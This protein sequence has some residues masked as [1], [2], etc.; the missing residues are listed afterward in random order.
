MVVEVSSRSSAPTE[1]NLFENRRVQ[2]VASATG[3][4]YVSASPEATRVVRDSVPDGSVQHTVEATLPLVAAA[5][6][7]GYAV[8]D[9]PALAADL[10][11]ASISVWIRGRPVGGVSLVYFRDLVPAD[12]LNVL[13]LPEMRMVALLIGGALNDNWF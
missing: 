9:Y 7:C 5:H 2:M 11:M 8:W 6:N 10:C 1:L 13:L 3:L 4:A 12:L